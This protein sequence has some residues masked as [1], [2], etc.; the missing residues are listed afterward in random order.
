M[1][2]LKNKFA[3]MVDPPYY[4]VVFASQAA[5]EPDCY[6]EMMH[7]MLKIAPEMDGFIGIETSGD[8]S[9]F[10]VSASYWD[11]ETAILKWRNHARHKIAQ[12]LGRDQWF[13]HFQ[14]RVAKVERQYDGP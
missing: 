8:E 13:D 2:T 4:V 11:S 14:I 6:T 7:E 5:N 12:D 9:G 10:M 1:K 3:P